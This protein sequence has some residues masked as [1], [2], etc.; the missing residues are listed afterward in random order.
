M[1]LFGSFLLWAVADR[2]SMKQRVTR[3][4]PAVA[5][6]KANDLIAV[7]LG[8]IVYAATILWFH[9]MLFSVRPLV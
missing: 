9:E 2:I 5:E 6:S 8:L 4:V 3:A 7:V 1:L